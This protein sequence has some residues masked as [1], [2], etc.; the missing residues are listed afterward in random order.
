MPLVNV[1]KIVDEHFRGAPSIISIDTE[2]LDLEILKTFD[3]NRH[4]PPIIFAR[5]LFSIPP[6]WT[7]ESLT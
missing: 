5:R 2:G 4:R 6:K 7:A 3:F 1:N